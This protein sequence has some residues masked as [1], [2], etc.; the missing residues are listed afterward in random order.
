MS[1]CL[2]SPF[3]RPRSSSFQR[4]AAYL[5]TLD[6]TGGAVNGDNQAS[7]NLGIQST[8]VTGLLDAENSLDPGDDFV[9]RGVRGLVEVDDTGRHTIRHM[10]AGSSA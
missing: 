10:S 8:T 3:S 5:L 6:K 1:Y 2:G 9:G 7:S 4:W